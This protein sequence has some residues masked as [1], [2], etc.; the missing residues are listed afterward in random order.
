[1]KAMHNAP[2]AFAHAIAQREQQREP[3]FRPGPLSTLARVI[4]TKQIV[5]ISDYSKDPAYKAREPGV[6]RIVELAAARTLLSV[7]MLKEDE[8]IGVVVIY[9]QEVRPFTDK[10]IALVQNFAAQAVIAI[11]NAR[12]LNELRESLDRQ[13]ATSEVLG[14]ISSSPG[15]LEPVF[16][17]MLANATRICEAKFGILYRCEG[18]ALRTVAMH[19]APQPFVEVRRSNPMIRP[20]PDTTL[21]RAMAIKQPVQIADILEELDPLDARAAQLPKLAGARTVLAVPMLKENELVGAFVIYRTEVRLFNDKQ[22][23]LVKNFANQAVIAIENTRL[24]NELRQRTTDL[25]ES[26]EQQTAIGKI[27]RVISN[28]PNDVQPVLAAVAE[29]AARICEAQFASIVIVENDVLRVAIR[30]GEVGWPVGEQIPLDRFTIAGRSIID[31]RPIQVAD[32]QQ[33]GDEFALGRQYATEIGSHTV[34]SVPLIREGRALGSIT[35]LRTE[36]RPFD[37]KHI[38]LLS[39]FA[40]QAAIAIENVRLFEAE[41]QRSQE[42]NE[43]LQQQTATADVLKVIS[44]SAFDLRTVLDTLLRF[45]A[46]LCEADHGTITQR[47][48]NQFHRTVFYGYSAAFQEYIQDLPVEPGRNTGLGRALLEGKVIH[49]TDVEA[50]PDYSWKE[51]PQLGEFR[52][53][54]GVPMLREGVPVG[55]MGLTRKEVRP[56]TDKQIELVT[57][58]ADQ[59]AIAIENVRLF[60]EIQDKSRQLEE[61]SQ[62]KSQFLANMSHELRTPLNAILGY[63]ELMADG[64]YGEPSEKMFGILKR[65]EA[66]GRH[67]LGT[68]QRRARSIQDRS[69]PTGARTIGLLHSGYRPNRPQHAGAAGGRQEARVQARACPRIASRARRRTPPDSGPDQSRRQCHQVHRCWRSRHQGRSQ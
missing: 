36:V 39:T 23:E 26:L 12:L 63:T 58:F 48:G 7:P 16:Q 15:E 38:A 37:Q 6:V 20:N 10:Q 34:L 51:G 60:D 8:L 21:G 18:D 5:H 9:R 11:E 66:N 44:R 35:I 56:F 32:L 3:L 2:P 30:L 52:T 45:A 14:V 31:M 28:S 50:D 67:L 69:W 1:M 62:H 42:L 68:H 57:T 55:V 17:A 13:T 40:D 25:A 33:A 22:I 46:R 54:L 43:L 29:N 27:L 19:D 59:A 53:M 64:A 41:Q 24:L 4:A 49:I 61:A 65:L 47:R